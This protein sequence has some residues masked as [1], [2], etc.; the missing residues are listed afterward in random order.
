M[1][2]RQ[3]YLGMAV[4]AAAAAL[5]PPAANATNQ[6]NLL[7]GGAP[8]DYNATGTGDPMEA[9]FGGVTTETAAVLQEVQGVNNGGSCGAGGNTCQET[10]WGVGTITQP[11]P[12]PTGTVRPRRRV[13]TS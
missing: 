12:M 9:H 3:W 6:P 1:T 4:A 7:Y 13:R 10:T 8:G 11:W 2:V 5:I